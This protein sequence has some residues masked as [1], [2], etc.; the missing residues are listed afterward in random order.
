MSLSCGCNNHYA[1]YDKLTN[2]KASKKYQCEECR[3]TINRGDVYAR[4]EQVYDHQWS[5]TIVCERCHDLG[6]SLAAM[7][8]CWMFGDLIETYKEYL[9]EYKPQPLG[10]WK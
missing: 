10:G 2:P 3:N 6:E 4:Y 9:T 7:G 8:F 5:T 1:D